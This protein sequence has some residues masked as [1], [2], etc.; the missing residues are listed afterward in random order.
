MGEPG[1][2]KHS[3]PGSADA[4]SGSDSPGQRAVHGA[5]AAG[6]A[7]PPDRQERR[8]STVAALIGALAVTFVSA[9]F[10]ASFIGGLHAPGP[11][12]VPVGLVGTP[13]QASSLDA[14]LNSQA[15]GAFTITSYPTVTAARNAIIHRS[16]DAALVPSSTSQLLLVAT[17]VS[18]AETNAIIKAFTAGATK[19]HVPLTVQ[20]IRPLHP[21]DPQGLAQLFFVVA[22][23][24][25]SLAFGNQLISRIGA[26][27][28]EFRHLAMIAVYAVIVAAVA[29]AIADPGIGALTGAPWGVFGIGVLLAFTAAVMSAAATRWAGGLGNIVLLLLFVPVGISSSGSTL[30]PRMITPWYADL[31]MALPPG[32]AQPVVRNVT[33]FNGNAIIN[34]LLILSAWA[35]AGVI[36]LV[37]AAVLHPPMPGKSRQ[38]TDSPAGAV[39]ATA[40]AH[41]TSVPR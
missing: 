18:Q 5:T 23:L 41:G 24:A 7:V 17:A 13:T 37:L 21:G 25:P 1:P 39:P 4:P 20:N 10:I 35:L 3:V 9:V 29:T 33:Y 14:K 11:R 12:S 22:L 8:T 34:P 36:A 38:Q 16:T 32:T 28:S 27:L 30:G 6:R 19:A 31:G 26:G 2:E 15:P 40:G